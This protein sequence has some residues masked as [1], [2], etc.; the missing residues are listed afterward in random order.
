MSVLDRIPSR[1]VLAPLAGGPSTV[2]L[3][4]APAAYPEIH[5]VTAARVAGW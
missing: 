2:A 3:A 1:I 5:H 4:T